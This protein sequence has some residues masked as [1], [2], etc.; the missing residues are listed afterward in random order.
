L[1]IPTELI[2]Q[3][4]RCPFCTDAF[5]A[6]ADPNIRLE[7]AVLNKAAVH[8]EEMAK[9]ERAVA[10]L[11]PEPPVVEE[12]FTVDLEGP[13]KV[14]PPKPWSTWVFVRND[15]DR[16][17]WGEMQAEIS[18]EGV[19]LYRG[20]KD[21]TV[22]I[23]CEA[24]W[25]GGGHVRVIVG[26]RT[27]EFQI[28]KKHIYKGRLA[29][30][31]TGFLNG[32]RPMP[33]NKGYRWPWYQWL[34]LLAPLGLIGVLI[35]GELPE[36]TLKPLKG[37]GIVMFAFLAPALAYL[38]WNIE[39]LPVAVRW[40]AATLLLVGVYLA[41]GSMYFFGPHLPPAAATANWSKFAPSGGG[42]TVSMP[43]T[44]LTE[45]EVS[46]GL[47]VVKTIARVKPN[48]TFI[49]AYADL[50]GRLT[51]DWERSSA[52]ETG[53]QYIRNTLYPNAYFWNFDR[54]INLDGYPG[55][56]ATFDQS[57]RSYA[58]V[59]VRMYL[60]GNRLYMLIASDTRYGNDHTFLGSFKIDS[61]ARMDLPTPINWNGLAAYWSFDE[62]NNGAW[63]TEKRTTQMSALN[64]CK[65]T[66]GRRGK[67]LELAGDFNSYIDYGTAESLNFKDRAPFTFSGWFKT[68]AFSGVMVSQ[69]NN[70]NPNAVL[71]ISVDN[72]RLRAEV[73]Q[74]GQFGNAAVVASN[75]N[76]NDDRWH[77]FVLTRDGSPDRFG[78]SLYLDGDR[79]ATSA[80]AAGLG[81]ITTNCRAFGCDLYVQQRGFGV[82][83]FRGNLDEI[84]MFNRV[85][86]QDEINQLAGKKGF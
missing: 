67:G 18:H 74:D 5:T 40:T 46:N 8:I 4:V 70:N 34:M 28:K 80:E 11:E 49:V 14:E 26:S 41:S 75:M 12:K 24:T 25:L 71:N 45:T 69:R 62:E 82:T 13:V 85:L 6:V 43:A 32:D 30:D 7:E 35:A 79:Q 15:S 23:G 10:L 16:R 21:L 44:T 65:L 17:L 33:V 59:V 63:V 61:K 76:V 68:Q 29:A 78:V 77:H 55:K 66:T 20:R 2:G 72:G 73:H 31:V 36:T 58:T 51:A 9:Q 86:T 54:E 3:T 84:C 1:R 81:P 56:E 47:T 38:L 53:R 27:V 39:R 42:Y 64:G 19:R 60:V 48:Q 22:P 52:F 83:S 57:G 50:P 37:F